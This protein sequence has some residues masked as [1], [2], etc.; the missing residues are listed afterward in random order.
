M[1]SSSRSGEEKGKEKEQLP[2]TA[3]F[4]EEKDEQG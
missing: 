3:Q 4:E 2:Y 1:S